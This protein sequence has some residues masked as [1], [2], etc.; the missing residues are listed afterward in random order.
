MQKKKK[1]CEE[2][3]TFEVVLDGPLDGVTKGAREGTPEGAPKVS[4]S[5]IHKDVKEVTFKVESKIL[6]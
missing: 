3:N 4:L 6:I 5:D 1:N 2:K